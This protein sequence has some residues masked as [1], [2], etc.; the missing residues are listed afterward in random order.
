[1]KATVKSD[2]LET[3]ENPTKVVYTD[4]RKQMKFVALLSGSKNSIYNVMECIGMGHELVC[5]GNL[6]SYAT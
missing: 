3:E 6:W 2:D 1:M 5:V 4:G